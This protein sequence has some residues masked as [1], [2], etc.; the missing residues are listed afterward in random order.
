V[1]AYHGKQTNMET[2]FPET[3]R[4]ITKAKIAL[5]RHQSEHIRSKDEVTSVERDW[6]AWSVNRISELETQTA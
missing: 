1:A 6:L 2:P 3:P 4:E 5:F